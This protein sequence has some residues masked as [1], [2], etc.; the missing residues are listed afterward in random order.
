MWKPFSNKLKKTMLP[1][2]ACGPM[3]E[4]TFAKKQ[5]GQ[6]QISFRKPTGCRVIQ[7]VRQGNW[8]AG[9]FQKPTL[10]KGKGPSKHKWLFAGVGKRHAFTTSYWRPR[11]GSQ[12]SHFLRRRASWRFTFCST[13]VDSA[14]FSNLYLARGSQRRRF[15]DSVSRMVQPVWL[16]ENNTP[17]PNFWVSKKARQEVHVRF[18]SAQNGRFLGE[19]ANESVGTKTAGPG[20]A[21]QKGEDTKGIDKTVGVPGSNGEPLQ[22]D[23]VLAGIGETV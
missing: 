3:R 22:K 12:D 23:S 1:P 10:W 6:T 4:A 18:K 21:L 19:G 8:R 13:R 9:V 16:C 17:H 15:A 7:D 11:M 20:L 2:S 5:P 14:T